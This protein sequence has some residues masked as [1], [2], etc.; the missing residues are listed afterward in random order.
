MGEGINPTLYA[1]VVIECVVVEVAEL[2]GVP[3]KSGALEGCSNIGFDKNSTSES[4]EGLK[5]VHK[6]DDVPVVY[7]FSY[8]HYLTISECSIE[9]GVEVAQVGLALPLCYNLR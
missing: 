5:T 1:Q 7:I 3:F 6:E 9:V 4:H 8:R 2:R